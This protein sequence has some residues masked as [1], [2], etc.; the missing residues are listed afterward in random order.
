MI[1]STNR[2]R[3]LSSISQLEPACFITFLCISLLFLRPF[4][5]NLTACI[6]RFFGCSGFNSVKHSI[7]LALRFSVKRGA[8]VG[9]GVVGVDNAYSVGVHGLR[10][11]ILTMSLKIE[12]LNGFDVR[13]GSPSRNEF[14]LAIRN[15]RFQGWAETWA[16]SSSDWTMAIIISQDINGLASFVVVTL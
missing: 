12:E 14:R 10:T 8:P 2:D 11:E 3:N 15:R 1:L 6:M 9:D 13:V 4:E 5:P 16:H 7:G